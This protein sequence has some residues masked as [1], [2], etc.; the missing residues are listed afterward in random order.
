MSTNI[1]T[2]V[3]LAPLTTMKVGGSAE[4]FVEVK[5]EEELAAAITWAIAKDLPITILGGGSNV[6]VSDN[7]VKGLV[8]KNEI[9]GISRDNS[10]DNSGDVFLEVG[11]GED[12]DSFVVYTVENGWWGVE[13]LSG[14]PGTVGGGVV[15]N[16]NAY[17][18]T[19]GDM[20]VEVKA[21]DLISGQVKV[22]SQEECQFKYRQSVFKNPTFDNRHVVTKVKLKLSLEPILQS[23]YRSATQSLEQKLK[24]NGVTDPEA[25]DIRGEIIKIRSN[26]GMLA[27]QFKSAGSFFTNPIVSKEVFGQVDKRVSEEYQS[28]ATK[29]A[30]WYWE[31]SGDEVKISAAFL[32]ECTPYNKSSFAD[33][34]FRDCVGISPLHTLS[35]INKGNATAEDIKDFTNSIFE[36]VKKKF[37]VE[38][39]SEV[40]FL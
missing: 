21:V 2:N 3:P 15:Q 28:I 27:G 32:M 30:P 16:I 9:K 4:Y 23:T 12:W 24:E 40:C 17:G 6:V 34:S 39:K 10:R 20:V 31:V 29:L 7:G 1:K 11:A 22:F 14:I 13:N 36:E 38:L 8:I 5:S 19:I 26:I 25:K 33:Q 37:G 18:V 35:V